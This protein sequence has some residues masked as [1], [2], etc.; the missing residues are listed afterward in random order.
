MAG[1]L[2]IATPATF[3]ARVTV[4]NLRRLSDVFNEFAIDVVLVRFSL[5]LCEGTEYYIN[6][7]DL[8]QSTGIC[9][10]LPTLSL[11]FGSSWAISDFMRRRKN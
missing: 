7:R 8:L 1:N 3:L 6:I 11:F 2:N 4:T 5:R 10:I 9:G